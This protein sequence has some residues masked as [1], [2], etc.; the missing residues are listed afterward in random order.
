MF[1]TFFS[2]SFIY[3]DIPCFLH[4]RKQSLVLQIYCMWERNQIS[5]HIIEDFEYFLGLCNALDISVIKNA[6]LGSNLIIRSIS[7][8]LI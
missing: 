5:V 4:R 2:N 8:K 1:S 3:R 6:L 7:V